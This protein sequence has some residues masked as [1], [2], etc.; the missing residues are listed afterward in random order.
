VQLVAPI[1]EDASQVYVFQRTPQWISPRDKYGKLVE[2][3]I[4][5]LQDNFPGYWNWWRY[6]AI[7]GL[8]P[9][10]RLHPPR[11]GVGE[12]GR[13]LEPDERPAPQGPHCV[14]RSQVG[15]DQELIAK[16][17]PDYAPFS[18]RPVVDN[19]WYKALTRDNVELVTSPIVRMTSEGIETEDGTVYAS[20]RS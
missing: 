1:A 10:P 11:R 19:G 17:L 4:V 3:E 2:P 14:H 18:R 9:D 15:G 7:A 16:L 5:W 8:F 12:A 20:T 6:M 13:A